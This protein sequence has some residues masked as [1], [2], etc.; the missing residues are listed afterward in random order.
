MKIEARSNSSRGTSSRIRRG[1]FIAEMPPVLLILFFLFVFPLINLGT[2]ALRYALLIT[3]CR[4]GAHVAA[5]SYTFQASSP[6]KPSALEATPLAVNSLA[7]RFSGINITNID[8]DILTTNI[9]SQAVTRSANK[10]PD[11]ANTQSNIYSLETIVTA[12]LDP[13]IQYDAPFVV[14]IPGLTKPWTT[15]VRAREYAENAQGLNQ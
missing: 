12:N 6:G 10:L 8:V 11:P 13:L 4:D 9:F 1:N 15:E 14:S 7:A 2:V 3:A 5:T